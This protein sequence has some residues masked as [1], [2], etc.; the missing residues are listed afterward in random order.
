MYVHPFPCYFTWSQ[1]P[2][3]APS[4]GGGIGGLTLAVAL[5]KLCGSRIKVDI[6]EAAQAFPETGAGIGAWPRVWQTMEALGLAADLSAISSSGSNGEIGGYSARRRPRGLPRG[7]RLLSQLQVGLRTFHRAQIHSVLSAHLPLDPSC[8]AH[9]NKRFVSYATSPADP[10]SIILTFADGTNATCDLLVGC[11]G[12]K[13]AVRGTLFRPQSNLTNPVWSG[14]VAYRSLVPRE[15]LLNVNP[16]HQSLEHVVLVSYTCPPSLAPNHFISYPIAQGKLINVVAFVT[17]PDGEGTRYDGEWTREASKEELI[18]AYA[19][20]EPLVAQLLN[21]VEKVSLWAI[22]TVPHLPSYVGERVALLGDAAHAMT[23]HQASGAGQAI[24][25]PT[26][27]SRHFIL[28]SL[29]AHPHATRQ[30]LPRVLQ[31]YDNIRRPFSQ[32]IIRRS[33]TCGMLYDY[34]LSPSVLADIVDLSGVARDSPAD[35]LA[36]RSSTTQHL[37]LWARDTSILDDRD[38]ALRALDDAL[39]EE[40]TG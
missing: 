32:D 30:T 29:L 17:Q 38:K 5:R 39:D 25:V 37:L 12:I 8:A 23:P 2:A 18:N 14:S 4:S 26:Y 28:G 19:G 3:S 36:R 9:F 6:Y 31:I 34:M 20:W 22:N 1:K 13:S 40:W 33:R 35:D 11:D 27:C 10:E 7:A 16:E 15:T 24:E 21:C